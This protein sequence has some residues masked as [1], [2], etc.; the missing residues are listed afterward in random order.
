VLLL[1]GDSRVDSGVLTQNPLHCAAINVNDELRAAAFVC[2][3]RLVNEPFKVRKRHPDAFISHCLFATGTKQRIS[4]SFQI[5]ATHFSVMI[6]YRDPF[7]GDQS[8]PKALSRLG[9]CSMVLV[10]F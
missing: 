3:P 8:T 5:F 1:L 10:R 4:S 7:T 9:Y 6:V 2:L